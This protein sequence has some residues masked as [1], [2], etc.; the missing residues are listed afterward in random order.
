M[1]KI[2][3]KVALNPINFVH[4]KGMGMEGRKR[5]ISDIVSALNA[6]EGGI[7]ACKLVLEIYDEVTE[8]GKK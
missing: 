1:M 2:I 8:T 3:N 7:T 6:Q 4:E 5:V